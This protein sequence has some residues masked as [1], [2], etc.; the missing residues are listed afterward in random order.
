VKAGLDE[1]PR[2]DE[3]QESQQSEPEDESARP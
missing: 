2:A 1:D 3:Q